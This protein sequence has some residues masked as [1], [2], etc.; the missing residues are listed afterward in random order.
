M[1]WGIVTAVA[2]VLCAAKFVT[3]RVGCPKADKLLLKLHTVGGVVLPVAATVHAVRELRAKRGGALRR[4]TGRVMLCG[5]TALMLS[6]VFSKQ[7]GKAWLKI[8]HV[9][10]VVTGLCLIAHICKKA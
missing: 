10:T 6:H 9:A 3:K 1:I 8:H 5:V 7:L 2:F 4:C